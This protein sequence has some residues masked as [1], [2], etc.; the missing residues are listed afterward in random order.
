MHLPNSSL[1]CAHGAYPTVLRAHQVAHH[2]GVRRCDEARETLLS[3]RSWCHSVPTLAARCPASSAFPTDPPAR[4]CV[5]PR[6]QSCHTAILRTLTTHR[7]RPRHRSSLLRPCRTSSM[8]VHDADASSAAPPPSRSA[9]EGIARTN[10]CQNLRC[11]LVRH[12]VLQMRRAVRAER[13]RDAL[14]SLDEAFLGSVQAAALPYH[15]TLP[16]TL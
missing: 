11:R 7:S 5:I 13:C 1:S 3:G 2:V 9:Y 10:A 4:C 15:R 14:S 6:R 12:P 16:W 8:C